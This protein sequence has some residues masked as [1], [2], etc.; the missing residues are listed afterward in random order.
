MFLLGDFDF[1]SLY[2]DFSHP[3]HGALHKLIYNFYRS[4]ESRMDPSIG[5]LR[6]LKSMY[7][8]VAAQSDLIELSDWQSL[9][10]DMQSKISEYTARVE[11]AAAAPPPEPEPE[12]EPEID[13]YEKDKRNIER[14]KEEIS[15]IIQG[16]PNIEAGDKAL[17]LWHRIRI[18]TEQWL[19]KD[20]TL[21]LLQPWLT[22]IQI[23][24]S[25]SAVEPA[26]YF[27]ERPTLIEAIVEKLKPPEPIRIPFSLELIR[28]LR[29]LAI[30]HPNYKELPPETILDYFNEIP[31]TAGKL[32]EL[33]W[34]WQLQKMVPAVEPPPTPITVV[35]PPPTPAVIRVPAVAPP[36]IVPTVPAV[37]AARVAAIPEPEMVTIGTLKVS[38]KN[39]AIGILVSVA[40]LAVLSG[41]PPKKARRK[42]RKKTKAGKKK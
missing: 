28:F 39:L 26:E 7:D 27:P 30:K 19:P 17:V 4:F 14:Y 32:F 33:G 29:A 38:R 42:P 1:K 20:E 34:M 10:G 3:E 35:E 16:E 41:E 9:S 23:Y 15:A 25:K 12:P 36:P 2:T 24:K 6:G 22:S 31:I 13:P 8:K 18:L 37:A 11:A 40:A 5:R 21:K